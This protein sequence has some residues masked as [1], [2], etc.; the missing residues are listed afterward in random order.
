MNLVCRLDLRRPD[1]NGEGGPSQ[2]DLF[3]CERGGTRAS[4]YMHRVHYKRPEKERKRQHDIH[5]HQARAS[6]A[7]LSIFR[8]RLQRFL[9][10]LSASREPSDQNVEAKRQQRPNANRQII[11]RTVTRAYARCLSMLCRCSLVIGPVRLLLLR[12]HDLSLTWLTYVSPLRPPTVL[13]RLAS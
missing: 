12:K 10:R 13:P 7:S 9:Y 2:E 1:V 11:Y 3:S 8:R 5:R 6:V 4:F